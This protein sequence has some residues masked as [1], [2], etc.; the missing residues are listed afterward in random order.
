MSEAARPTGHSS[1]APSEREAPTSP[2]SEL[3]ATITL[4]LP[5]V[6]AQVGLMAMGVVDTVMVGHVSAQVL[7]SVALGNLYV[8]NALVL[9]QGTVMALDPIVAQAAGARDAAA[10]SRAVQ[11]GIIIALLLSVG[12]ALLLLPVHG[13]LVL[14]RQQREIIPDTVAY[15]FVSIPGVVPYLLFV[16]FRQTLQALHRVAPIVWTVVGANLTNVALNWIFVYGH[17]GSPALGAVG[18][19]IGTTISR[20][21]MALALL[22]LAWRSL[23]EHLWPVRRE[24]LARRPLGR[25]LWLGLPIGLQQLLES[26]AFGAIGLMMGMLGTVEMAAHQI[27]I[28]LAALTFMVPLGVSSAAAVRVGHAVGARDPRGVRLAARAAFLCGMSFMACTALLFLAAPRLLARIFTGDARI[29]AVAGLLIPVAGVFQIFD[30]AQAVGAGVLRGMG[31]TRAPLLAMIAGYWM[32]GLP[33]SIA[34][35]FHT[36]LRAAGLWWGF[37]A[38]LGAVALFLAL[39]IRV[40]FRRELGRVVVE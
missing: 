29:I 16:V 32:L 39:R 37:V 11:R 3:R 14:T 27:A 38:S 10:V 24:A 23:R 40:L 15:V 19:A 34:L 33:V 1:A 21:V 22:L 13:V 31:D 18:S 28:T 36:P 25:V 5:L 4:A 6:L 35:G 7:A 12:T 9:G 8:F 2:R 17:L 30:G 20:W 26:G